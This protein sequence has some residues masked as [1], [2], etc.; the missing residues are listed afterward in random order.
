[1]CRSFVAT[2]SQRERGVKEIFSKCSKV[3]LTLL[4]KKLSSVCESVKK[5]SPECSTKKGYQEASKKD[6]FRRDPSRKDLFKFEPIQSTSAFFKNLPNLK[7][8]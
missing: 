7:F 5:N 4:T 2:S 6:S 1:M 3:V 8:I